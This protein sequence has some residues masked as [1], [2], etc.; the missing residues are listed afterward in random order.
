MRTW[1]SAVAALMI[2]AGGVQPVAAAVPSQS[3]GP[4]AP[5]DLSTQ[6]HGARIALHSGTGAV[7]MVGGSVQHPVASRAELGRPA[8]ANAAATA[9]LQ[10]NAGLF[11]VS[12]PGADLQLAKQQSASRGRTILRYQQ[13]YH[14]I[15]VMAGDLVVDVSKKLDIVSANGEASPQLKVA[16]SATVSAAAA[17]ANAVA[18][19]AKAG[20]RAAASLTASKPALWIYDSRLLGTPGLPIVSLV[21]RLDVTSGTPTDVDELVLIDAQKGFVVLHFN[22]IETGAAANRI[23]C[24]HN[25]A[26]TPS[27]DTCGTGAETPVITSNG[28]G[29]A[30]A[31]NDAK[32]AFD[33]SG[34]T[35]IYYYNRFG[36]DS[37][38]GVGLQLKST[39]RYCPDS[40]DCPYANAFWNGTQMV[41]GQGFAAGD[42][43]DGH[44]LTHGFT[45][46]TSHL[47][48]FYQSG[49][50]NEAMS[51]IMGEFI[52][53]DFND[54]LGNDAPTAKWLIGEDIPGWPSGLRNMKDPTT[55]A[56]GRQPDKMTSPYYY[57][58]PF[59]PYSDNGGVHE[60]SGVANKAAYL[61]GED[62]ALSGPITFN[63]VTVTPLGRDK[64]SALFFEVDANLLTSGSDYADLG[65]D[66]LQACQNLLGTT[67]NGINGAASPSGAFTAADCTQVGHAVTATEM[68]LAPTVAGA[69]YPDAP[70]CPVATP[71][72]VNAF[73]D[74]AEYTPANVGS[75]PWVTTGDG[76]WV[77]ND[78]QYATSVDKSATY[79]DF[80][81]QDFAS[82]S[83][84]A[85]AMKNAVL[86]PV[87][88]YL[89]FS[90][91]YVF[92]YGA[93]YPP[94]T[95]DF[96]DGGRVEYTTDGTTWND[97]GP[98]ITDN[99][100]NGTLSSSYGNPLGGQRAFSG[101]SA[102]YYASRADLSTLAGQSVKFRWRIVTD[103]SSNDLG[104]LLD[105]I[106]VYSCTTPS[107]SVND[108]SVTE[109]NSGTVNAGF[110]VSLT[111]ASSQTVTVHYAT[112]DGTATQ[113]SDYTATSGDLTFAPGET[114]K[115]VNV[116]VR[117]D[118][119]PEANE[120][121]TVNLS[122]P[123]N[124]SIAD[125]QGLGTINDDD[126][127]PTLSVNDTS[128]TE[129]NS[130]TVNA[131]FTVSLSAA[132]GQ[133]VTVHYATADGTATQPGDY[134]A[135][136]GDLTFAPGDISKPVNVTV[137]GD[138]LV[139][140]NETFSVVLSAPVNAT[141]GDGTGV[142]TILNDDSSGPPT[143]TTGP[144][145]GSPTLDIIA[146]TLGRKASRIPVRISFT[147][148][149]PSGVAATSL[150]DRFGTGSV[151]GVP[152]P[153]ATALS[154]TVKIAAGEN[155]AHHFRAKATDT[156]GNSAMGPKT[157]LHA[158][159]RQDTATPALGVTF[160][161]TWSSVTNHNASGGSLKSSS[162]AGD[163]V[164]LTLDGVTDFAWVSSLGANRGM[165]DVYVDGVKQATV[166]LYSATTT[167][168]QVVFSW[169]S[170]GVPGTHT[171]QIRVL[172]TA[173]ASSLGTRVD[174][175]TFVALTN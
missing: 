157:T 7:R 42:D 15:P 121:F 145:V 5:E 45:E 165:A 77:P 135:T 106:A 107:L 120:T 92:D 32:R 173:N 130:G 58:A 100:Y 70:V 131:A 4:G 85:L 62:P 104:W 164:S 96:Y 68:E 3:G 153:S 152:L 112:A 1:S 71:V 21:W 143:D 158:R 133:T 166:D 40:F 10:R 76:A 53:Q 61:L 140:G 30:T 38:D 128:V 105:D 25:E 99:G 24:D 54:G 162:T 108:A 127:A 86:I 172:G 136:S 49:A 103:S 75:E 97:L 163:S 63:G 156:V 57:F 26:V 138:T 122:A 14:G 124:A 59:D 18:A 11:G 65:T 28:T 6:F 20:G 50:I 82:I 47:F 160:S 94:P 22:Q 56:A 9:F 33:Y 118:T 125:G 129:G 151:A 36:R 35:W 117:G 141:I 12:D 43:V 44:E 39:V 148:T 175:D 142:G 144:S 34:D 51:D 101:N 46:F 174:L 169:D 72:A 113:P 146:G 52:D 66:M 115:P 27:L 69:G 83:D 116:P 149:D 16:T 23:V 17:R 31:G 84:S 8:N 171:I 29:Y 102:G 55:S 90:Q 119:L 81:G 170:G 150:R 134:T 126:A 79:H 123:A 2:L 88:A 95:G 111:P 159:L 137:Q 74:N 91:A 87:G 60:N 110:T 139:E 41:Y 67:P 132:S 93:E 114:S 154:T 109:G 167:Y 73:S 80:Y 37:L 19:V 78:D 13:L 147:A 155:K 161:G 168:R 89:R 64:A 98:L 48:Y